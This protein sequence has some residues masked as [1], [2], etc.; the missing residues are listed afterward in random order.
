[1]SN[2]HTGGSEISEQEHNRLVAWEMEYGHPL[3][4]DEDLRDAYDAVDGGTRR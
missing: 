3:E 4:L 1:M 2:Q